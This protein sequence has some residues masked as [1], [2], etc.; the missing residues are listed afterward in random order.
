MKP[1]LNQDGSS[2]TILTLEK[3]LAEKKIKEENIPENIK[4]YLE[5]ILKSTLELHAGP[6]DSKVVTLGSLATI[7]SYD[8]EYMIAI[9]GIPELGSVPSTDY[10]RPT[11]PIAQAIMNWKEGDIVKLTVAGA[12]KEIT[13]KQIDQTSVINNILDQLNN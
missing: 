2:L 7:K 10:C 3:D 4:H 12:E 5:Q 6:N 9:V 8:D 1:I 13:I 11:S